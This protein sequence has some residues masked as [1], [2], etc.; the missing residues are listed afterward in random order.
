MSDYV[1]MVKNQAQVFL[2]GPPLVKMATGDPLH[3]LKNLITSSG[4]VSDAETLGGA[5]MHSKVSGVSD[6]LARDELHALDLARGVMSSIHRKKRMSLPA[7]YWSI[8]E[9]PF[10]SAEELL[11]VVPSNVKIPFD[12]S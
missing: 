7:A 8:V 2:G 11:G 3:P 1:I 4:E 12:V 5:E 10:Y 9:K 6:F